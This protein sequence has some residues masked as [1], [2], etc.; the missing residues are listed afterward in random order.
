MDFSIWDADT[1]MIFSCSE[2]TKFMD[3]KLSSFESTNLYSIED[4]QSEYRVVKSTTQTSRPA[5]MSVTLS[6]PSSNEEQ[7]S[8]VELKLS[9]KLDFLRRLYGHSVTV[10]IVE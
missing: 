2:I 1:R 4:S 3:L 8:V 10:S 7:C 9:M 5:S 6:M